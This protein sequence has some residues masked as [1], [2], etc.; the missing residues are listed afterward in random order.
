[1]AVISNSSTTLLITALDTY[2]LMSID[3]VVGAALV[4]N[5]TPT[6]LF[7]YIAIVTPRHSCWL[8]LCLLVLLLFGLS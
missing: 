2:A 6:L 7:K 3:G 8:L 4:A 1:M 5:L